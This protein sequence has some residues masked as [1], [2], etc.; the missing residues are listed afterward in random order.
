MSD[1]SPRYPRISL[2][3]AIPLA[4]K[5]FDGEGRSPMTE[6]VAVKHWGYKGVN[7]TSNKVLSALRKYGLLD[8]VKGG[9][10]VSTDAIA[11]A[12]HRDDRFNP[13]YGA[14]VSRCAHR[15]ELFATLGKEFGLNASEQNLA[16]QLVK[17]GFSQDGA[18]KAARAYRATM[19][20]VGGGGGGYIPPDDEQHGEEASMQQMPS[21]L[22]RPPSSIQ[23][24]PMVQEKFDLEEGPVTFAVPSVLSPESYKD[25]ADRVEIFLRGL[26]RRSDAEAKLKE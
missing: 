23:R 25:L 18:L 7:G 8:D 5:L 20:L 2:A 9:V 16:A 15:V 19:E 13:D 6:E 12:A 21:I 3:D 24:P 4:L 10:K 11:I 1:R 17:R 22:D 14:A 26:K